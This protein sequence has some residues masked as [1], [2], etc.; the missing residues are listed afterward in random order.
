M[1][2]LV[3][4]REWREPLWMP[5]RSPSYCN[6]QREAAPAAPQRPS[7][8]EVRSSGHG[9]RVRNTNQ[10]FLLPACSIS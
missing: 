1:C 3:G 2:S 10:H 7:T 9:R 5:A 6:T 4:I 8:A